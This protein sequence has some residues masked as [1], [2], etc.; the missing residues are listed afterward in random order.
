MTKYLIFI[1][2]AHTLCASETITRFQFEEHDYLRFD[3]SVLHDPECHKCR[4]SRFVSYDPQEF[5]SFQIIER[6]EV[7]P[8]RYQI[9]NTP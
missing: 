3:Q 6:S 9:P 5:E 7:S 2:F 1:L 8:F 4:F